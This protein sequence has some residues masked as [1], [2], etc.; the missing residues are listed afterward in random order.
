MAI[1]SMTGF[2]RADGAH[3][4]YT[5]H[6]EI[7]SVNGK[8]LEVRSRLPHGFEGVEEGM[9][10]VAS[11]HVRRGNLQVN[12]QFAREATA[13]ALQLN[14]QVADRIVEIAEELRGRLNAPPVTVEAVLGV[15]GVLEV[16]EPEMDEDAIAARNKAVLAS[17]DEACAALA[18]ARASEGEKLARLISEQVD[19]VERLTADARDSPARTPEALRQRLAGQIE[20]IMESA[21]TLDPDRLHQEAMVMAA[22]SDIQE[23]LDRLFAHVQAARDLLDEDEPVGRKFDFLAQEFN[24]EA[25]TLCSKSTDASLTT[26]GLELKAVIDQVR[27]QVQNIE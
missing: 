14:Q 2:A 20:R 27:E 5:W 6:W 8:T 26:I 1:N 12:L 9:R 21:N 16:V 25:N 15:R 18:K 4:H 7:K 19:Q 24:R 17:F 13:P 23:E 3:D 10:Q 11:R 22:K